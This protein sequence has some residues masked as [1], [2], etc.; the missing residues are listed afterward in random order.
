M[1]KTIGFVKTQVQESLPTLEDTNSVFSTIISNLNNIKN[2]LLSLKANLFMVGDS[3]GNCRLTSKEAN[4]L[5]ELSES[6]SVEH[7]EDMLAS[8]EEHNQT[9]MEIHAILTEKLTDLKGQDNSLS[10][11]D[12]EDFN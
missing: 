4:R 1:S 11:E 5:K 6:M 12:I 10:E 3:L 9:V 2:N 8:I 7:I